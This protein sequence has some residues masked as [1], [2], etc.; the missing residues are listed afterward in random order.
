[1]KL[2]LYPP[3]GKLVTGLVFRPAAYR[4]MI[5]NSGFA[6]SGKTQ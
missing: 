1:M 2:R 6:R 3:L 5:P 4:D